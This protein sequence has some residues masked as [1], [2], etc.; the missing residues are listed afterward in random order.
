MQHVHENKHY[1]ENGQTKSDKIW[2]ENTSTTTKNNDKDD[3][4]RMTLVR[5]MTEMMK[6]IGKMTTELLL[7]NTI[8]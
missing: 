8:K 7:R 3:I 4:T 6:N 1:R 2:Y 5:E